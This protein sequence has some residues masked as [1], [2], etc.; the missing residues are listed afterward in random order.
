MKYSKSIIKKEESIMDSFVENMP[1]SII[2]YNKNTLR[3]TFVNNSMLM[4]LVEDDIKYIVNM[5][6]AAIIS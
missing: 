3:I 4:M 5:K 6:L 2:T 1:M